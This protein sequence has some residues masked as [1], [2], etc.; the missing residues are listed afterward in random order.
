MGLQQRF[1]MKT[2]GDDP[3]K[4][5][6]IDNLI[7][8]STS[9]NYNFLKKNEKPL[10]SINNSIR[11]QPSRFF[12]SNLNL[13]HD[14]YKRRMTNLSW[15]TSLRISG[16]GGG[17]GADT[18][19]DAG[20][21]Y[22]DFGQGGAKR[23]RPGDRE[24]EVI[25]GSF[26]LNLSHSYSRGI[27]RS[28][29]TQSLDVSASASPANR[30]NV[31][32]SIYFDLTDWGVKSQGLSLVRDLHCWQMEFTRQEYGGNSQYYFRVF[33]RD[34]PDVKYERERR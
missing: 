5:N 9:T 7:I 6:K 15:R 25:G 26:N 12:E 13:A 10:S 32:Y 14:P 2:A 20:L 17:S 28:N 3:G 16:Q 1:H 23:N 4:T 19:G 33:L 31:S 27:D 11:L 21:Q 8:W 34:I 18:T 24:T 22:G 30:W 29:E